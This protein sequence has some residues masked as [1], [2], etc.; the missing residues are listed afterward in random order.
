MKALTLLRHGKSDWHTAAATDHERPISR[1]GRRSADAVGRFLRRVDLVPDA[2]VTSTA[3]RARTTSERAAEAGAWG[4]PILRSPELYNSHPE[5]VLDA[6][7]GQDDT[8]QH[9]LLTGHEPAWSQVAS[10]LI[11][12]GNLGMVTATLV[13][14][15]LPIVRWS[16]IQWG[17]AKLLWMLPP[18][19][20]MAGD[21]DDP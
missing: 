17:R 11:D 6:L 8:H 9:L 1:R 21:L 3:V 2:V 4:C 18:R 10:Q 12:G 19:L 20:L 7:K 13:H 15:E 16:Q 14:I 5:A